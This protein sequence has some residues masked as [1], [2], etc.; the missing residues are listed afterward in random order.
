MCVSLLQIRGRLRSG[1]ET[2]ERHQGVD[3][4]TESVAQRTQEKSIPDQR[5]K[6]HAGHN[7][8]DDSDPGVDLVR[9]REAAAQEGKQN[10]MGAEKQDRRR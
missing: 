7:H 8:K 9:E 5:R 6:N 1:G 2:E 3:G 10:D 4:H